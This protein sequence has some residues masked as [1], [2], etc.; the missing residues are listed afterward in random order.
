MTSRGNVVPVTAITDRPTVGRHLRDWR[1]RRGLSQLEL[2]SRAGVSARHLSFVE[3]GRSQ[4]TSAMILRLC[5]HLAVPLRQQNTL[6][7]AGG[8]APAYPEEP[9]TGSRLA[10][11]N[12]AVERILT[13]HEPFPALVI[14]RMWNLVTANAAAARLL[15]VSNP[16]LLE[17]PV[18]VI[19]CSLHPEGLAPRIRNLREWRHHLIERLER[20]LLATG[21]PALSALLDE[22]RGYGDRQE[23]SQP[24]D[25]SLVV[26]LRLSTGEAELSLV[27]T[28]TVFGT[29][30]EV[31]VSELAIEAFYPAD[32]ATRRSLEA[33]STS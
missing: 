26:P 32:E 12:S 9:L 20:D 18:N 6:L 22:V 31:T 15:T 17:P 28:T 4:P 11:V 16:D 14:D 19:R 23:P 13:G 33:A 30:R 5:E 7:L 8:Y 3:T 27:S 24:D 25:A 21:D 2:A 29:P 1:L 10:A